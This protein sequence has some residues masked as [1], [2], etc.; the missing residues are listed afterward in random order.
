[1]TATKRKAPAATRPL[2]YPDLEANEGKLFWLGVYFRDLAE[3]EALQGLVIEMH[4]RHRSQVVCTALY[5]AQH[6]NRDSTK[7]ALGYVVSEGLLLFAHPTT[8]VFDSQVV[9]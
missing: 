5:S 1:M 4:R 2:P 6:A 9:S 7:M 8:T 3:L